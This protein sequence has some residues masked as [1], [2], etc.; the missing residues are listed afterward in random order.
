MIKVLVYAKK[1]ILYILCAIALLFIQ[2]QCD[3]ALPEYMSDIVNTG[4]ISGNTGYILQTGGTMLLIT[5]LGTVCSITVGYFA[6]V[7]AAG[8]S[9]DLRRDVFNKVVHFSSAE[10]DQFSTSSLITRT[11]N[12]ITQIQTLLVMLIRMVFYAPILGVGGIIKALENS[13]TMSWIIAVA[14]ICLVG[15][16]LIL[17]SIALPKFKLVQ[18]LVD[19]LNLVSRENLE[20]MLVTRAFNSQPFETR[21][22][23]A[24]NSDLTATSLFVNRAMSVMMPTMMLIMNL[25]TVVIVWVGAKQVSAL[26]IGVGDMMAY[27]QYAMQIIMSFLMLAMMF[28]LIPRAAVSAGRIAEVLE[29]EFSITD[30]EDPA[31]I[32]EDFSG[33]VVFDRVD[34]RFPGSEEDVLHQ[35]SFTA[36]PGETT[37]IIGA[38]GSGKSTLMSL[39]LRFYDVTGGRI[40]IG[41]RDIREFDRRDLRQ[42]IGYVPQKNV[43]FSGTIESNLRYG[44]SQAAGEVL[45]KAAEVAQAAEFI[46]GK[47][48]GLGS[49]VAQGGSNFSGGQ[50][51]RLAIARALVK[52]AP[53]YIFDDSFSA[54][55]LKTDSKLR[56]AL[57]RETG[58]STLLLIAQRVGTIMEAEQIIVL[59]NGAIAGIGSHR[60][61]MNSC[62]VY[63]QIARSQLS[64]KELMG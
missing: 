20:G 14:V 22:F 43:L 4:V 11:T 51:Q 34:F 50:K 18:K 52:E 56:Q 8:V 54:L 2:A 7:T 42:L 32:P 1:Y 29:A 12:D 46:A 38:T 58:G 17:F 53:I 21:R 3:L 45:D 10:L 36:R 5:L 23:D 33:E 13:K 61:L 39:I 19:R 28:I 24:A 35:I 30:P 27:M 26:H 41:G 57:K 31:P 9:H 64:E 37:A 48:D 59:D 63:Q 25:T 47:E 15:L 6:A 16:V 60:E 49:N 40:L 55:D 44:N 62:E